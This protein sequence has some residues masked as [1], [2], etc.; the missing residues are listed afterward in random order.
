MAI[1]IVETTK[2]EHQ[3]IL[4]KQ[5]ND[6]MFYVL[7][8]LK[9]E[10]EMLMNYFWR[11]PEL[12]PQECFDAFGVTGGNLFQYAGAAIQFIVSLD[13]AYAL[14][15]PKPSHEYVINADNSVT[16]GNIL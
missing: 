14:V 2:Q 4:R 1:E 7:Q 3:I 12:T 6:K 11:N 16:V 8:N 10:V 15:Y 9:D 5:V 13:P